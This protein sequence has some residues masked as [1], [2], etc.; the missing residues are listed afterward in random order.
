MSIK[1]V[2]SMAVLVA[3]CATLLAGCKDYSNLAPGEP[4]S[5]EQKAAINRVAEQKIVWIDDRSDGFMYFGV[6]NDAMVIYRGG[7]LTV[8]T[9]VSVAGYSFSFPTNAT[10]LVFFGEKIYGFEEAYKEGVLT[11]DAIAKIHAYF[12]SDQYREDRYGKK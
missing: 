9:D 2:I 4:F 5:K 12:T 8:M 11:K 10:P 7:A 6:Y 3:I 1:R